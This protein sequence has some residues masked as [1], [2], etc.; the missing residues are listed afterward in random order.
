MIYESIILPLIDHQK[1]YKCNNNT[2]QKKTKIGRLLRKTN[3]KNHNPLKKSINRPNII[4]KNQI[5]CYKV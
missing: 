5:I 1:A 2:L 3:N 4:Q